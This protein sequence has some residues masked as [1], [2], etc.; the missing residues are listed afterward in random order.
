YPVTVSVDDTGTGFAVTA[1]VQAAIDP[2]QVCALLVQALTELTAEN[3]VLAELDVLPVAERC[4]LL[5]GF[6][7]QVEVPSPGVATVDAWV[8]ARI[9]ESP[10]AVAVV[11][12]GRGMTYG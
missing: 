2:G 12:E 10:D 8:W 7:P 9:E 11:H 5:D 6:N 4:R 3:R 1:Q